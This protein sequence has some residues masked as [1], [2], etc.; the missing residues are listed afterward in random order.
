PIQ[1][2]R[3]NPDT[4][5]EVPWDDVVKGLEVKK[6]TFYI[7]TQEELEELRPDKTQYIDVQEFVDVGQVDPLYYHK[8]YY[9]APQDTDEKP[10]ILFREVLQAGARAAVGRFVMREKEYTCIIRAYQQGML[11][12]TLNYAYEVRPIEDIEELKEQN[13]KLSAQERSLAKDLVEKLFADEFDISQF[14]DT[15]VEEVQKAI[16]KKSKGEVVT[17]KGKKKEEKR[18]ELVSALKASLKK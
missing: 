14:K 3:I 8:H 13:V 17:T 5:K 6:G 18:Q 2:K 16:K 15:F 4:G 9:L 1:Y 12:T 11:L 10:Y 7:L